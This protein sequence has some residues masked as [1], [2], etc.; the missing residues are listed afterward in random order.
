[1]QDL[2]VWGLVLLVLSAGLLVIEIFVPTAGVLAV[3]SIALA[4]AGVVCLW[5]FSDEWGLGGLLTMMVVGPGIAFYGLN[6]YRQTP[7]G[8]KMTGADTDDRMAE[9]H[10]R[11]EDELRSRKALVGKTGIVLTE[12]RPIGVI[13][14]DGTR[15]D[16]M[17]ETNLIRA[18]TTIRI[19][20]V[21]PGHVRVR[22]IRESTG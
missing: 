15:H 7:L 19:T 22:E 10:E 13:E 17:S 2:L 21:E 11:L 18:G 12:L 6:I 16:A 5:R 4:V 9:D 14:V 20:G 3:T 1:M 8:R